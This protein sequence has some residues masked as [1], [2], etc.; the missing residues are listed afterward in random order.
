M[1]KEEQAKQ[2]AEVQETET[3]IQTQVEAPMGFEDEDASDLI[4]PR[5]K[6]IN[7]LSPERKDKL[8]DEGD[9]INSLTKD[10][11]NGKIFIPIYKFTNVILWK[12]RADGGG[13]A[14]ISHDGKIMVPTD[15][16]APYPVGKLADFDNTKTG[17]DAQ[18]THV[19]YINFFGFIEGERMP[20]ILSFAKTNYAEGKRMYSLAKVSMKNMWANGYKLESKLMKK[21]AN[22]WFNIVVVPNGPTSVEDQAFALEMYKMFRNSQLNFDVEDTSGASE[23]Q[24][25]AT[26]EQLK[27][28]EF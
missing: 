20:I 8:A 9:I 21:A 28:A 18:P 22:E 25:G 24:P 10:K 1:S 2:V 17:K 23:P 12:D 5:I 4:I 7:A 3:Q 15:G 6:V 26:D 19:K 14:A 13:I 27:D 16:S 11:L